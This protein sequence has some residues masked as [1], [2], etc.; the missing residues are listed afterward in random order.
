MS[1]Q[2]VTPLRRGAAF[3]QCCIDEGVYSFDPIDAGDL[4]QYTADAGILAKV[5]RF[6][7]AWGSAGDVT[8][9]HWYIKDLSSP[10]VCPAPSLPVPASAPRCP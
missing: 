3:P 7:G 9:S 6:P 2:K 8:G 10:P 5:L 1:S 4:A